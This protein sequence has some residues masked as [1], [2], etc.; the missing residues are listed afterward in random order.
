LHS[1][2]RIHDIVPDL[3]DD[4]GIDAKHSFEDAIEPVEE[5]ITRWGVRIAVMGGVD[6]NLLALGDEAAVRTRVRRILEH[7][8]PTGAYVCGSGNSIPNY[9]PPANYLAMLETLAE[10]NASRES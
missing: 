9:V 6:V 7:A 4:V 3:V 10:F 1:C 8:A 5:F 2:G